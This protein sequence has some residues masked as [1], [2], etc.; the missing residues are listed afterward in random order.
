MLVAGPLA[1]VIML[2]LR[3]LHRLRRESR[4][5]PSANA[6]PTLVFGAGMLGELI[7][8]R[9]QFD[10]DSPY[11][12]VGFL[13]PELME[14]ELADPAFAEVFLDEEPRRYGRPGAPVTEDDIAAHLRAT[15]ARHM[16]PRTIRFVDA[17]P[18]NDNGKIA[19]SQIRAMVTGGDPG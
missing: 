2:G 9:M 17:L 3:Y 7:V 1:L 4:L 8:R 6:A 18:L 13:D 10:C 14:S 16:V 12:P 11:R 19:K 5:G 15:L